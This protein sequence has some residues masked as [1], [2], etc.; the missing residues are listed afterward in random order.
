MRHAKQSIASS[1]NDLCGRHHVSVFRIVTIAVA[2]ATAAEL[3]AIRQI[4]RNES[5]NASSTAFLPRASS[6]RIAP[7]FLSCSCICRAR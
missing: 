4:S 2:P 3:A 7:S 6:V 5:T 1:G